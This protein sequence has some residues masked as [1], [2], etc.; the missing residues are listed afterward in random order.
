MK[1]LLLISVFAIFL[2]PLKLCSQGSE[3]FSTG[4]YII[5]MGVVPQTVGNGMKPYGLVY[6]LLKNYQVPVKWAIGAGKSL[7]GV[8]FIYSGKQYKGGTFLIPKEYI[9]ATVAARITYWVSQGVVGSYTLSPLTINITTTLTS[10]PRWS[11]NT[12]NGAIEVGFFTAAGIPASAYVW[13]PPSQLTDCNDIFVIPHTDPTWAFYGGLYSWNRNYKGAIWCGCHA[14]S[15]LEAI[16]NPSNPV[17]QCNFLSTTGLIHF[18]SH[19]GM[20]IPYTDFFNQNPYNGT[21]ITATADDPV[22]QRMGSEEGAHLNGSEKIYIPLAGGGWRNTTHL[23]CYDVSHPD[24][25]SFPNG[26]AAVT[27]YGR[28]FGLNTAG[29]VM[30][31]S[32]HNIGGTGAANVAAMREFFNF[33]L[34]VVKDKSPLVSS[35]S[36]PSIMQGGSLYSVSVNA[37]SPVSA[38][39][40]YQWSSSYAGTFSSPNASVTNFTPATVLAP[41]ICII[42]CIITD[43]C[44]RVTFNSVSVLL[45][46]PPQPP[47][48]V[49]DIL[50]LNLCN[51][52]GQMNVLS[53]DY[54]LN[55]DPLSSITLLSAPKKGSVTI[56]SGGIISYIG[57]PA[58]SGLD[59]FY[60]KVCDPG[61][62]CDT[63]IVYINIGVP[64]FKGCTPDEFEKFISQGYG[65]S[66]T[67]SSVSNPTKITGAPDQSNGNNNNSARIT[68]TSAFITVDLGAGLT[69]TKGDS[70][71]LRMASD[72]KNKPNVLV[73]FN[74]TN[75]FPSAFSKTFV[76]SG[77]KI[78]LNYIYVIPS[79]INPRYIKIHILAGGGSKLD[80][81]AITYKMYSC[82]NAKPSANA[83]FVTGAKNAV[84]II[85]QKA[86]DIDP[87]G[88][89]LNFSITTPPKHGTASV[90]VDNTIKYVPFGAYLGND[91]IIY[92]ACNYLCI[93]DTALVVLT[94]NNTICANNQTE[95]FYNGHANV[96]ATGSAGSTNPTSALGVP[97]AVNGNNGGTARLAT[98]DILILD[99]GSTPI[100]AGKIVSIDWMPDNISAATMNVQ[101]SADNIT[102]SGITSFSSPANASKLLLT[103]NY[104]TPV[105]TRYLKF[106]VG[107]QSPDIDAIS[108]SYS[109]CAVIPNRA[110]FAY[111]DTSTTLTNIPTSKNV[112]L[113]DYDLDAG[114]SL[115]VGLLTGIYGPQHGTQAISGNTITY[116]PANSFSGWDT[117]YYKVCDNGSPSFCDTARYFIY[118]GPIRPIA[119]RD[120][121]TM[122]SNDSVGL[123]PMANDIK[124]VSSYVYDISDLP[125]Y[126]APSNGVVQ[127]IGDSISYTPLVGFTGVDSFAYSI[128]DDQ[129]FPMCDTA[130]I[131]VNVLNQAPKALRDVVL[132]NICQ[133]ETYYPMLNDT[134]AEGAATM[135]ISGVKSPTPKGGTATT[136]GDA[137]YYAAPFGY[138]GTDSIKYYIKDLENPSKSDSAYIF[139]TISALPNN[140]PVAVNDTVPVDMNGEQYWDLPDNDWDPDDQP[141]VI[142]LT[143]GI[144]QPKH[145]TR[146]LLANG[147]IHYIPFQAFSGIDSLDYIITDVPYNP[148]A[149]CPSLTPKADTGRAYFI[150]VAANTTLAANDN[151]STLKNHPVSGNVITNDQDPEGDG[152]LFT[153]FLDS[154][155][156]LYLNSGTLSLNGY[157]LNGNYIANA[158][159]L[160][161]NANG[162]YTF[163]PTM[164]FTG[165]VSIDYQ[166]CDDNLSSSCEIASLTIYVVPYSSGVTNSINPHND[167][168]VGYQKRNVSGNVLVNDYDIQTNKVLFGGLYDSTTSSFK[169]SGSFNVAGHDRNENPIA[170]A[171][172]ITAYPSGYFMF[173]PDSTFMGTVDII[174]KAC[175]NMI[176]SSCANAQ[177]R[178]DIMPDINY[179]GNDYPFG[180][181]DHTY[182]MLNNTLYGNS[183]LANDTDMNG[184][185]LTIN[186]TPVTP[187]SFGTVIINSNGTFKYIPNA[188]YLGPDQFVYKVCDNG[189]PS[190]CAEAT[191]YIDV[192]PFNSV[193]PRND[194]NNTFA[195]AA[196]SGFVLTNDFDPEGDPAK[197]SGYIDFLTGIPLTQGAIIGGYNVGGTWIANAGTLSW[198]TVTGGYTFTPVAGFSGSAKVNYLYCDSAAQSV[199]TNVN[200]TICVTP[201]FTPTTT[202]TVLPDNDA[203]ITITNTPINGNVL[204]NDKDGEGNAIRFEGFYNL[205]TSV[206]TKMG[207][208]AAVPGTD[209][210]GRPA[211]NAGTLF[212]DTNGIFTFT[213]ALNFNGT[214]TINYKVCD[215][216]AIPQACK[217]AS[218]TIS[219]NP[220]NNGSTNKPPVSGDD[221][222]L[223]K[224]GVSALDSVLLNDQDLNGPNYSVTV[225]TI[226]TIGPIHGTI[227]W[228]GKGKFL[229]TANAAYSGPD[230]FIYRACDSLNSCNTSTVYFLISDSTRPLPVTLLEFKASLAGNDAEVYWSTSSEINSKLFEVYRS[231]DGMNFKFL[232]SVRAAGNSL[233][234]NRY[235]ITDPQV[236][237]L[238]QPFIYYRLKMIDID[239]SYKWSNIA[240]LKIKGAKNQSG[241]TV[242]FPNPASGSISLDMGYK[243][244][245]DFTVHINDVY[246]KRVMDFINPI[247]NNKNIASFDISRLSAGLYFVNIQ[248][249]DGSIT[250]LK[251]VKE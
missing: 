178:I 193:L 185:I 124:S 77:Q 61:G 221:F 183:V 141:I 125:N 118:A 228:L 18:G 126:W 171:G 227:I 34:I 123:F 127:V 186:T 93:C 213:P 14:V 106:S 26:P 122:N 71:I 104:T 58:T 226:A 113:N 10:A 35:S 223:V 102:F 157:D 249:Y 99:I 241:V 67:S 121:I 46:P 20:S 97:D 85:N 240:L 184:N 22:F 207:T 111:N 110:P 177:M 23:G 66:Q 196:V 17:E 25:S 72:D 231:T 165:K 4:S 9:N 245:A 98:T 2:F 246:G 234:L 204:L 78:Y 32:G 38:S 182:T 19:S 65:V 187:P 220:L 169:T 147:L 179:N 90:Q 243:P 137:V 146:S 63:G 131:V 48:A 166:K 107:A 51:A 79:G 52:A 116:T 138:S 173:V 84:I 7:N 91:T 214:V 163:T 225:D 86:N 112:S 237:E 101:A 250:S 144:L 82:T 64:S 142:S 222:V 174:Y 239:G 216:F 198:N 37:S 30:Y 242:L 154:L 74:S 153:G 188:G 24:V 191:V 21:P 53:N 218:L 100:P 149:G 62:S 236:T 56:V 155:N 55:N 28:G 13:V 50:T 103:Y 57:Y 59:S 217:D 203:Y 145:G 202:N 69:F 44:G 206:L 180:T 117:L 27:L 115:T 87:Q 244:V 161:I 164:N 81:D 70:I 139:I 76:V 49:T 134:N 247:L 75:T 224:Q 210:F 158:G 215:T 136:D 172:T 42:K 200:L 94:I 15:V 47:V 29:M 150:V 235:G 73:E 33:A 68:S 83:D 16:T 175:D 5:N 109:V 170:Y 89:P 219:V 192:Y 176:S 230:Y 238:N 45:V 152:W 128:C 232:Q 156:E 39:L 3:T 54:D 11:L 120:M 105:S 199:C 80:I 143:N 8:D 40:S 43:A 95:V 148:G 92:N 133:P 36:V 211:P 1:Q 12:Q 159:L 129:S 140:P 151:N 205:N 181:D 6:D 209:Q 212:F 233:K 208:F 135:Y 160:Q 119:K 189:A 190:L 168:F 197:F 132:G 96:V 31:Q 130:F 194:N 229:Y 108:Y 195:G 114:Q 60:Y 88:L 251:F 162:S 248:N 41:T 167:Q 201:D